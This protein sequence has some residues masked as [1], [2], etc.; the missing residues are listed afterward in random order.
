MIADI[1]ETLG[2]EGINESSE[3]SYDDHIDNMEEE[4]FIFEGVGANTTK[5]KQNRKKAAVDRTG[6]TNVEE[7]EEQ[8]DEAD[9]TVFIDNLPKDEASIRQMIEDVDFHVRNLEKA[10]FEEEDSEAEDDLRENHKRN[11]SDAKHNR[12]LEKLL[13]KS[14]IQ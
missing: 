12:Q 6:E 13:E 4:E 2:E 3:E 14:H 11:I 10:F 5:A 8:E 7:L 9:D 1:K